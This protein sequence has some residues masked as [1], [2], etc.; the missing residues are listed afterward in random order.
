MGLEYLPTCGEKWPHTCFSKLQ[1][2]PLSYQRVIEIDSDVGVSK[3]R[4]ILP[5]KWMV[6]IMENPMNKWM[7]L[8]VPLFLETPICVL[9]C[10][11][12]VYAVYAFFWVYVID[13][14][15]SLFIHI[16]HIFANR[17]LFGGPE[18]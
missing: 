2:T 7:I 6:K 4:G 9:L 12:L 18:R 16:I 14:I 17:N 13:N 11:V 8:G 1:A 3:N 15:Y 5:P 10:Y